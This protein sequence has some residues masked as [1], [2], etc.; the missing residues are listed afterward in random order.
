MPRRVVSSTR[1]RR[2]SAAELLAP[3]GEPL[4]FRGDLLGVDRVRLDAR[5]G[6][7]L[8]VPCPLQRRL[9]VADL[10]LE[11]FASPRLLGDGPER[12]ER[13]RLLL[14]LQRRGIAQ[15]REGLARLLADEAVQ[16]GA[17][18]I[19]RRDVRLL[20]AQEVLGLGDL[21][22]AEGSELLL[23]VRLRLA[24][25]GL[26]LGTTAQTAV[27]LDVAQLGLHPV[28]ATEPQRD[29]GDDD[30]DPD[31][32]ATGSHGEGPEVDDPKRPE[33][34]D[35]DRQDQ[36]DH[37]KGDRPARQRSPGGLRRDLEGDLDL[38][39]QRGAQLADLGV[40]DAQA[41]DAL[42]DDRQRIRRRVGSG[43]MGDRGSDLDRFAVPLESLARA[44]PFGHQPLGLAGLLEEAPPLDECGVRVGPTFAG[45]RQGVAVALQ[46]GEC[47]LTGLDGRGRRRDGALGDLEAS[48]VLVALGRQLVERA[49]ELLL[50]A[51]RA[52]VRAADGRL[53][54]VAQ[55]G[56]VAGEIAQLVVAHR[57]CR[58]EERLGRDA[59]ELGHDLVGERRVGHRLAVV[60]ELDRALLAREGLLE[61]PGREPAVLFLLLELERDPRSGVGGDVP[62]PQGVEIGLRCS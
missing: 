18:H 32:H 24:Q 19:H 55:C 49:V 61:R 57:G 27:D 10:H 20:A 2:C 30:A 1:W 46:L 12:L 13:M 48:G 37:D 36:A 39:G 6:I 16:L 62:R 50:R 22:Q 35:P 26:H 40:E 44:L 38:A 51:S 54:P 14:D 33:G 31:D 5:P 59:R 15:G 56:L 45:A 43:Q 28:A 29:R 42:A 60:L 53:Q 23:G 7:G 8:V 58:A 34:E 3:H 17:E 41:L 25:L 21:G 52:A 47:Q 9:L 11:P 4:G